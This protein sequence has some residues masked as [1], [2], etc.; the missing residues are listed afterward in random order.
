M[1]RVNMYLQTHW[2]IEEWIRSQPV[3]WPFIEKIIDDALWANKANEP[4]MLWEP[5]ANGEGVAMKG[6]V[7]SEVHGCLKW[8]CASWDV[9][10]SD[11]VRGI[12][13]EAFE[14]E[15]GYGAC[16]C[17]QRERPQELSQ[18]GKK[19]PSRAA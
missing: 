4:P 18:R 7:S 13:E 14:K 8:W 11:A 3:M 9:R 6:W 5:Y 1:S 17:V 12:L 10:M 2:R 19:K 16:E 15:H